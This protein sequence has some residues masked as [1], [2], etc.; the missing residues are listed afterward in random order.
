M[1]HK[2]TNEFFCLP[3]LVPNF[4][5]SG[6]S[7]SSLVAWLDST[8]T[9]DFSLQCAGLLTLEQ[10]LAE[11]FSLTTHEQICCK[12][13]TGWLLHRVRSETTEYPEPLLKFDIIISQH[14][15]SYVGSCSNIGF[16]Y[17]WKSAE[18]SPGSAYSTQ[19]LKDQ[20]IE[21]RFRLL[22]GDAG[23]SFDH[24]MI[25]HVVMEAHA[26]DAFVAA[27]EMVDSI[28]KGHS[29]D[30]SLQILCEVVTHFSRVFA[31]YF[32][33]EKT[34]KASHWPGIQ[35]CLKLPEYFGMG[36]VQN[37]SIHIFGLIIGLST[38]EHKMNAELEVLGAKHYTHKQRQVVECFTKN[39]DVLKDY[40][41]TAASPTERELYQKII[42]RMASWRS[43]H[44][45]RVG[46][47]ISATTAQSHSKVY[48]TS[49]NQH[50]TLEEIQHQLD[51]RIVETRALQPGC[52]HNP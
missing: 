45:Q 15:G 51:H 48:Q 4:D 2:S 33:P 19:L 7:L 1:E 9:S 25:G 13:V 40:I 32:H 38:P 49:A 43:I 20:K 14:L 36:G 35:K 42:A 8:E 21:A 6:P 12:C 17:N 10:L 41:N 46:T 5:F 22:P 28:K 27:L 29:I 24:F 44:K 11:F 30:H 47:Y 31:N 26:N 23:Q 52:P 16:Y 18:V 3:E 34:T 50:G 39:R 37:T